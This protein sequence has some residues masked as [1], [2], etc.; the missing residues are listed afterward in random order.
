MEWRLL[1][2]TAGEAARPPCA[3][4]RAFLMEGGW[5]QPPSG[6]EQRAYVSAIYVDFHSFFFAAE[7][8]SKI[9]AANPHIEALREH[10]NTH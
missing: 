10:H 9:D 3:K 5:P 8:I 7:H 1:K 2:L 6:V 4:T